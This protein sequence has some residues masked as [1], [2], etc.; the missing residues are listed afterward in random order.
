M[1]GL[2]S[3]ACACLVLFGSAVSAGP[4]AA[5]PAVGVIEGINTSGY[6]SMLARFDTASPGTFTDVKPI[7]GLAEGE[8]LADVDFRYHPNG[9]INP[10]PPSQLFG[11]AVKPGLEYSVRLYTIDID[12]AA[13][14]AVGPGF[15]QTPAGNTYG[16]DFN[17]TVD[18]VRA[19]TDLDANFRTNPNNG[20][21]A[22]KDTPLNPAGKKVA[23]LA[24]DRV[25][26]PIPPTVSSNTTAYAIGATPSM[27]Y[28]IG[29]LNSTPSPNGGILMNEKPLGV[30]LTPSAPVGFDIDRAGAAFATMSVAGAP[31]LYSI[32]LTTGAATLVGKL[33]VVLSGF[34]IVPESVPAPPPDT[35]APAVGLKGVK[36]SMSLA[37]F[38][39][40]VKAKVTPSEPAKLGGVLM[41]SAKSA[42]LASF[43]LTLATKSLKLGAGA[44]TLKLKPRRSLVGHPRKTFKARLQVTATDAA[45]NAKTVTKTIKV[46]PAKR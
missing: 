40:G 34:A 27:L 37:S 32:N 46:K 33:P 2:V 9:E 44:R 45:G 38:L 1:R 10:L 11:L 39:K 16:I 4:A 19:V 14:T 18:R 17:P 29:G 15:G 41:V 42:Q 24:Y 21:L 8:Y 26:I 25:D 6:F 31:E 43:N 3:F 22:G 13:A 30:T 12:T 36:A 5:E 7:I 20:T 28:T 35:D 23:G